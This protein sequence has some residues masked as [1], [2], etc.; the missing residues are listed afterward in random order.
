[1]ADAVFQPDFHS[2]DALMLRAQQFCR[3]L[4]E[5]SPL[6]LVVL[7]PDL[8]IV[9]ANPAHLSTVGRSRDALA[10]MDLFA[11]FPDNPHDP[12]AD[13]VRN[14]RASLTRIL[15]TGRPD[16][17]PLQRYDVR[18]D[19]GPWEVRYWRPRNWPVFDEQGSLIAL[20]HHVTDAT[21]DVANLRKVPAAPGGPEADLL[22]RAD[23]TLSMS[24]H[25]V[26]QSRLDL[27]RARQRTH[28]LARTVP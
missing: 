3:R 14:L 15:E 5:H 4:F 6:G 9:D 26:K 27:G 22:M 10:G 16:G 17:M 21:V 1:M 19:D 8:R 23:A 7:S 2:P 20:V 25:L 24:R 28:G 13:G 12:A 18:P 11:A